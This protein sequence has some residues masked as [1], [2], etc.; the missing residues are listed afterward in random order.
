[1]VDRGRAR[2]IARAA[3]I[4]AGVVLALLGLMRGEALDIARKASIVCI[5]CIGIG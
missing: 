3:L 2:Q 5:E 1:M 4:A